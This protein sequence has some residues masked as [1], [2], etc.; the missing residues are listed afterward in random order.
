MFLPKSIILTFQV[1]QLVLTYQ[2][3]EL[4]QEGLWIKRRKIRIYL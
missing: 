1:E 2:F 4:S 3:Y